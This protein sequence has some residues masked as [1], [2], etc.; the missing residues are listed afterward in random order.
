MYTASAP[1]SIAAIPHSK[2]LAGARS[3]IVLGV[4]CWVLGDD[5]YILLGVGCWVLG[6][7]CW[8]WGVGC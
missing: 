6:V 5:E 1:C 3:S 2:F 4:G 7:E 8:L